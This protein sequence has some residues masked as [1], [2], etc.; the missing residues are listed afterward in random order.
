MFKAASHT[1]N[2]HSLKQ[3]IDRI[4]VVLQEIKKHFILFVTQISVQTCP[5][6]IGMNSMRDNSSDLSI[7]SFTRTLYIGTHDGTE[8]PDLRLFQCLNTL[9]IRLTLQAQNSA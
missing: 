2:Y 5:N 6:K 3:R 9:T 4:L 7:F 8:D 1:N